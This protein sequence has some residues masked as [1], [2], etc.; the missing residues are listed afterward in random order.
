[1]ALAKRFQFERLASLRHQSQFILDR[2]DIEIGIAA[3]EIGDVDLLRR[4]SFRAAALEQPHAAGG[5]IVTA[6]KIAAAADRPGLGVGGERQRLLNLIEQ[7]ESVA[8]LAVHLVDEGDDG[9]I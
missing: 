5:E 9:N 4:S 8:A 7:I 3:G 6:E 2:A 1:M